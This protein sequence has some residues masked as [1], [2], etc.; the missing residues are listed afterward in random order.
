MEILNYKDVV[1]ETVGEGAS[2][3]QIRWIITEDMGARNFVM[4]HFEIMPDGYTPLHKH[5]WEHEVFILSGVG[6]VVGDNTERSFGT[7]DVIFVLGNELHQFKNTGNGPLTLL[8]LIPSKD[9]CN[10]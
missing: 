3:V 10:L 4:R 6:K 8:C 9:R 7:G 2:G 5:V 1:P